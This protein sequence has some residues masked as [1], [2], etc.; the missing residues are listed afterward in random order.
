M[1][2]LKPRAGLMQ[3]STVVTAF[4][5]T[6][7]QNL[8]FFAPFLFVNVFL[9]RDLSF[10]CRLFA[11]EDGNHQVCIAGLTEQPVHNVEE[12]MEVSVDKNFITKNAK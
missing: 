3:G 10:Q 12:L 9:N 11:R 6:K 7:P 2:V 8:V 1:A 4:P 5:K